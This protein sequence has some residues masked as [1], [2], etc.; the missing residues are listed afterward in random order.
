MGKG[1]N[2]RPTQ[3]HKLVSRE[4][5]EKGRGKAEARLL[6]PH[7]AGGCG[8]GEP[9]CFVQEA[10]LQ[11]ARTAKTELPPVS[12]ESSPSRPQGRG[13]FLPGP[14]GSS[15]SSHGLCISYLTP[16]PLPE[17]GRS[18]LV[19]MFPQQETWIQGSER[20]QQ[21]RRTEGLSNWVPCSSRLGSLLGT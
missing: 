21:V 7:L 16:G 13:D 5:M 1:W 10:S 3:Q 18:G 8:K 20:A 6:K 19:L 17:S 11:P 2:N 14:L 4:M 9:K 15:G 12:P